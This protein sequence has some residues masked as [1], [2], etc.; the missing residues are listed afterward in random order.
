ML[1]DSLPSPQKSI[2]ACAPSSKKSIVDEYN[3]HPFE[4][5]FFHQIQKQTIIFV[6][7]TTTIVDIGERKIVHVIEILVCKIVLQDLFVRRAFHGRIQ[8]DFV[9]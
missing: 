1:G 7:Y 2:A 8:K 4:K 6:E 9:M 5:S 3:L